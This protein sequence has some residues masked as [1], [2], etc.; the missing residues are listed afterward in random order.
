MPS[1]DCASVQLFRIGIARLGI[2]RPLLDS[3]YP[4]TLPDHRPLDLAAQI[5]PSI[6]RDDPTLAPPGRRAR[7]PA[8]D[9]APST[10]V[11]AS[12]SFLDGSVLAIDRCLA[13]LALDLS[14]CTGKDIPGGIL[15]EEMG[16][17]K[18]IIL[19]SLIAQHPPSSTSSPTLEKQSLGWCPATLVITPAAIMD[20]WESELGMHAPSLRPIDPTQYDVVLTTYEVLRREVHAA[21][22]GH[23]ERSRRF[24]RK[25]ERRVSPLVQHL[26]WRVVLDEAQMVE[27]TMTN[28]ALVA[29][30]I[31]RVHPWAVTGTPT[32][33]TGSLADM[34]GLF[35]FLGLDDWV[36]ATRPLMTDASSAHLALSSTASA[37]NS[38]RSQLDLFVKGHPGLVRQELCRFMH[39]ATKASVAAELVIPRQHQHVIHL[40]FDR[41]QQTYYDELHDLCVQAASEPQP[42]SSLDAHTRRNGV[43]RKS[44]G[45]RLEPRSLV[46][47]M[48][49]TCCHPQVGEHNRRLLGADLRSMDEVLHFM[50]RQSAGWWY[51]LQSKRLLASFDVA[52]TYEFEGAFGRALQVYGLRIREVR[53]LIRG[54]RS[55]LNVSLVKRRN[56]DGKA[57]PASDGVDDD[58]E[59]HAEREAAIAA[60]QVHGGSMGDD[61]DGDDDNDDGSGVS[62]RVAIGETEVLEERYRL[63]HLEELEHRLLYFIASVYFSIGRR[64]TEAAGSAGDADSEMR[65]AESGLTLAEC[66]AGETQYYQLADD[67]RKQAL[68]VYEERANRLMGDLA[69]RQTDILD[70]LH[71]LDLKQQQQQHPA[72]SGGKMRKGKGKGKAVQGDTSVMIMAMADHFR[73]GLLTNDVFD[74][75]RSIVDALNEQWPLLW[76]WRR[77]MIELLLTPLDGKPEPDGDAESS[78][79]IASTQTPTATGAVEKGAPTGEEYAQG[80]DVQEDANQYQYAYIQILSDRIALLNGS[81]RDVNRRFYGTTQLQHELFEQRKRLALKNSQKSLAQLAEDLKAI[82]RNPDLNH[83]ETALAAMAYR[84]MTKQIHDQVAKLEHLQS[85]IGMFRSLG[86][87]RIVFFRDL[88]KFDAGVTPPERPLDLVQHREELQ[89]EI[90]QLEAQIAVQSGRRRYL[91]HLASEYEGKPDGERVRECG[92]CRSELLT[93]IVTP[94]GHMFCNDCNGMWIV[95]HA[96]CP[97]CNQHVPPKSVVPVTMRHYGKPANAAVDAITASSAAQVS[98]DIHSLL[99]EISSIPMTG[100]YGIKFDTMIRHIKHILQS[101]PADQRP[102]KILIFSQWQQVLD[103]LGRACQSNGIGYMTMEGYGYDAATQR[104][105]RVK[106]K[107]Q[108]VTRFMMGDGISVFMLNAKSQSSGLTLVCA[109]HVMMVEPLLNRSIERQAIN[110][111]HRI[112]QT[113]ET[114]VWRY[115]VQDTIEERIHGL[116]ERRLA[117]QQGLASGN[118]SGPSTSTDTSSSI[119]NAK[120]KLASKDGGGGEQLADADLNE[121]LFGLAASQSSR[122]NK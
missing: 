67:L 111:V 121:L 17:G 38:S 43:G 78:G 36:N 69:L 73:G 97:M 99:H 25:Y 10:A 50:V 96:K 110:R 107:G 49:Q 100:S 55:R 40:R 1:A 60:R 26:W 54:V 31:P 14:P 45:G 42:A 92:V 80:L 6:E 18:T 71:G 57:E 56:A 116:A 52:H 74:A 16:L 108:S 84:E 122:M 30:A 47:Q 66:E 15:A 48:R 86:N 115:I 11:S 82:S 94:C 35:Q 61:Q 83:A 89:A 13:S 72:E 102:P 62:K 64:L 23:D 20:Q 12:P 81:R 114:H 33:R 98:A 88:Q 79:S 41:I 21:R 53:D 113:K 51:S 5:L 63:R 46:L 90:A 76:S 120:I 9:H 68:R 37:G 65:D 7:V 19:M 118:Q 112:G 77:K 87:A 22:T 2:L 27:S 95:K 106:R 117:H 44:T 85:E 91:E 8:T 24:E 32:S 75:M 39:R 93:G 28:V 59:E 101:G 103:I 119:D 29:R 58:D 109:T 34:A 104:N 3:F 70:K 4:P 105:E